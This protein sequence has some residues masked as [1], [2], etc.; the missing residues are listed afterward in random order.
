MP[1][2]MNAMAT[3]TAHEPTTKGRTFR[4]R[5]M[6]GLLRQAGG[7]DYLPESDGA[8][9]PAVITIMVLRHDR[10]GTHVVTS[11]VMCG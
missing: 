9:V 11:L 2:N 4:Y 8:F 3:Y 5:T 10:Y 7:T 6:K 1:G